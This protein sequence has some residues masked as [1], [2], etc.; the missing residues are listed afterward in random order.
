MAL[1]GTSASK[2]I[3]YGNVEKAVVTYWEYA[4]RAPLGAL[5]ETQQAKAGVLLDGIPASARTGFLNIPG[6]CSCRF[7]LGHVCVKG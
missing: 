6:S 2:C 7:R 5:S 4:P 3:P 1:A